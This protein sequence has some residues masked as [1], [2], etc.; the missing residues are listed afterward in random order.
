MALVDREL[1]EVVLL[2]NLHQEPEKVI[3]QNID[4]YYFSYFGNALGSQNLE[5]PHATLKIQW[6]VECHIELV[7][8]GFFDN[9]FGGCILV[10]HCSSNQ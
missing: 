7:I 2:H 9:R 1:L 10:Q 3:T 4:E 5:Y 6:R 8:I